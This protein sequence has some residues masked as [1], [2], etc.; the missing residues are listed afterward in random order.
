VTAPADASRAFDG[1]ETVSEN[2]P[3]DPPDAV[4]RIIKTLEERHK[5]LLVSALDQ[6]DTLEIDG[7]FLCI[8]FPK[9]KAMFKAQVESRDNRKLLEEVGRLVVGRALRLS[10]SVG[11]K[12]KPAEKPP[13]VE[14][15]KPKA[16]NHPMVRAIKDKFH[17]EV[18]EI[19]DPDR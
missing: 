18:V 11:G 2:P 1:P 19:I 8:S 7:G 6:A 15:P 17:G 9:E 4:A 10:A 3:S 14:K 5:K 16:E 12:A 13:E